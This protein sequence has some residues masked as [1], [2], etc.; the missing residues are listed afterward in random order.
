MPCAMAKRSMGLPIPCMF[1][2]RPVQAAIPA[3]AAVTAVSLLLHLS[4]MAAA[5]PELPENCNLQH[6]CQYKG[7]LPFS[8]PCA[9]ASPNKALLEKEFRRFLGSPNYMLNCGL[10]IILLPALGIVLLVKRAALLTALSADVGAT[11]P[12]F[13]RCCW[14]PVCVQ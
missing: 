6:R 2:V 3:M 8:V 11:S 4:G 14:P 1:W 7:S 5:V 10:G 13:S 9:A 12:D